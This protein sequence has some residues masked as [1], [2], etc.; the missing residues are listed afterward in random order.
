MQARLTRNP[1]SSVTGRD[2]FGVP[3]FEDVFFDFL[4]TDD[5]L[6]R[7]VRAIVAGDELTLLQ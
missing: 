4:L 5:R 3:S 1:D 7:V 6:L 2:F